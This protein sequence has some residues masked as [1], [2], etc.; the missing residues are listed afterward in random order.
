MDK[1]NRNND[2]QISDIYKIIHITD[3]V[4]FKRQVREGS[5]KQFPLGRA[6]VL[7]RM[8]D[9]GVPRMLRMFH[10]LT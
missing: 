2:E 7:T 4:K 10:F 8:G 9:K 1:P 6:V 3:Y 5:E